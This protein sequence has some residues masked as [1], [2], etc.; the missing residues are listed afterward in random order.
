[1]APERGSWDTETLMAQCNPQW[2]TLG[3]QIGNLWVKPN[4][5]HHAWFR[6]KS[7]KVRIQSRWDQKL[8]QFSENLNVP[9]G[10]FSY[11]K[12]VAI[13]VPWLRWPHSAAACSDFET[14]AIRTSNPARKLP[15]AQQ[16]ALANWAFGKLDWNQVMDPEEF[17]DWSNFTSHQTCDFERCQCLSKVWPDPPSEAFLVYLWNMV[18]YLE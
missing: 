7:S 4:P 17:W 12:F 18:M 15:Q 11:G 10:F 8:S 6:L 3:K 13:L 16:A 2:K 5:S 9:L 14:A 1:M